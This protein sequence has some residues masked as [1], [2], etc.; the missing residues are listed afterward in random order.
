LSPLLIVSCLYGI[1][2][3]VTLAVNYRAL[4]GSGLPTSLARPGFGAR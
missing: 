3:L 2:A 1:L 4:K